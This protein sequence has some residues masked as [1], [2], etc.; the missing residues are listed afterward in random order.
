MVIYNK[1]NLL[2]FFRTASPFSQWHP[3]K[4]IAYDIPLFKNQEVAFYNTEQYMMYMKA[5]TF[6]DKKMMLKIVK[7]KDPKKVKRLGRQVKNFD[8]QIWD[9]VKEEIVF[10]GNLLKFSQN[11]H[12]KNKL[13]ETG[14]K[15]LVEASPYDRIWGI[16]MAK[17]NKNILDSSKW[18][19]KNLLGKALMKVR[20]CLKN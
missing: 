11:P 17:N 4:I 2:A 15:I 16:G 19:G 12:L 14:D 9:S 13:L 6:K 8:C 3:A 10:N 18:R 5:A 20:N 1:R 7:E